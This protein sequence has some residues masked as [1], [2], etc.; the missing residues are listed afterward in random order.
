MQLNNFVKG[1]VEKLPYTSCAVVLGQVCNK[2]LLCK[3]AF[4]AAVQQ[5]EI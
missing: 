5:H 1:N 4:P 2:L 3:T